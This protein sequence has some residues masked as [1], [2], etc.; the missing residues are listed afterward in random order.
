[1]LSHIGH[2]YKLLKLSTQDAATTGV[3]RANCAT[4]AW[5]QYWE[6]K[7]LCLVKTTAGDLLS[8]ML[9]LRNHTKQPTFHG[10]LY[11]FLILFF[12]EPKT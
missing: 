4:A 3:E 12:K 6:A 7:N 5:Q 9:G 2:V 1:M 11:L 10:C 8:T